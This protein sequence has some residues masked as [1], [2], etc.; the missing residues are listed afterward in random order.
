[1]SKR[2]NSPLVPMD[3]RPDEIVSMTSKLRSALY[4]A[5]S[6]HDM[7]EIMAKQVQL[8]KEGNTK[9][10]QT[11]L[12]YLVG[13]KVQKVRVEKVSMHTTFSQQ[14]QREEDEET[15]RQVKRI[16]QLEPQAERVHRLLVMV[17]DRAPDVQDLVMLSESQLDQAERWAMEQAA[18][19]RL[20]AKGKGK[21]ITWPIQ[22]DFI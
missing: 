15:D 13:G 5:V 6:E 17:M 20:A 3:Q 14:K 22:P 16:E 10:V 11:V 12:D 19:M 4:G 9:A 1:M 18:A 21:Q 8:A 7:T 2:N